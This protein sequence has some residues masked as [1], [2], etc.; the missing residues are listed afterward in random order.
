MSR[1]GVPT[2]AASAPPVSEE[3]RRALVAGAAAMRPLRQAASVARGSGATTCVIAAAGFPISLVGLSVPGM[4]VCAAL[5]AIG[6]YEMRGAKGFLNAS[7][8]IHLRLALN[9]LAL[10]ACITLYCLAQAIVSLYFSG[11]SMQLLG[12]QLTGMGLDGQTVIQAVVVLVYGGVIAGSAIFQGA[13]ALYYFSRGK[14]ID[15]F[16]GSVP[17][18]VREVLMAL[19]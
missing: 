2:P 11:Q 9:Q 14:A 3:Q 18:W 8:G 10:L 17:E 16:R 12:D 13:M 6:V 15:R 19:V 4:L 5:I 7:P 1:G